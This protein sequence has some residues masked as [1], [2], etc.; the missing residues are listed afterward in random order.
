MSLRMVGGSWFAH[1]LSREQINAP[2]EQ[3]REDFTMGG[4]SGWGKREPA[5]GRRGKTSVLPRVFSLLERTA[6]LRGARCSGAALAQQQIARCRL[7]QGLDPGGR[8]VRS[9]SKALRTSVARKA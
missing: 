3:T 9:S 2:N 4:R 5:P 8:R 7:F 1:P 6:V